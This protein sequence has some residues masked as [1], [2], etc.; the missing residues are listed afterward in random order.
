MNN[1][2]SGAQILGGYVQ[3][4][5]KENL[6][7]LKVT[8]QR[9][10]GGGG[11]GVGGSRKDAPVV[12]PKAKMSIV[13]ANHDRTVS[14]KEALEQLAE[15]HELLFLPKVGKQEKG[16]QVYTFGKISVYLDNRLVYA[17]SGGE[18]SPMALN[19]L[20]EVAKKKK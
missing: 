11:V 10:G 14:F 8:E 17:L 6:D 3:P 9:G 12:P 13:D 4:G 18:W 7:Y 2:V 16:K 19:D 1:V 20:L 5:T 15:E